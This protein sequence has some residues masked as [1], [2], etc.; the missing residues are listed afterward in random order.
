MVDV[1]ERSAQLQQQAKRD[2]DRGRFD[3]AER[4]L[5]TALD[6]LSEADADADRIDA[7]A[8][9]VRVLVTLSSVEV[10]L[11]GHEH[12]RNSLDEAH[13]I[14][15]E[16]ADSGLR[17]AVHNA[18]ALRSLRLGESDEALAEFSEAEEVS[19]SV[20]PPER[21]TLLLNRGNLY[22]HKLSLKAARR[23]LSRCI[24][25][26][27]EQVDTF[28]ELATHAFMARHNLGWLEF[29]AGNLP[30][31]LRLMDEAAARP[32]EVS[33]A[34]SALDK[35]R[36]LIEAGLS[37]A[38]DRTLAEAE[39][40]F[41]RGRLHQE[42]AETELARAD[43]AILSSNLRAA[44]RRA[45]SAR[46][47]F[48]RRG[49][50]R[51]SQMAELT[52]LATE[53]AD[54]ERPTQLV[55][56]AT[57]LADD[58]ATHHLDQH[59]RSATLI[60]ADALLRAGRTEEAG[61]TLAGL[62]PVSTTD[63]L[64]VA[65]HHRAVSAGLLAATGLRLAATREIR[66]GLAELARHQAQF[67]SIDLQTAAAI[68]GRD[69]VRLDLDLALADP[70]PARVFNTIER[71]R[72]VSRRLT[73]V[74]PRT[75]ESAELLAEL[76]QLNEVNKAMATDPSASGELAAV[77]QRIAELY[78]DLSAL[79]WRTVG[80]GE[81]LHPATMAR[82]ADAAERGGRT[83]VSYCQH[84]SRW[85]AVV[86]GDG[87]PHFVPL[88]GD[89]QILEL[90]R[91]SQADL[92]V[93]ALPLI[94]EP[95]R[96]S[97]QASLRRSLERIDRALVAPLRLPDRPLAI[98]PTGP[99]ATLAWNCLPSLRGRPVEVSPNATSWLWGTEAVDTH[100]DVDV[101]AFAGPGLTSAHSEASQVA[102]V[103]AGR[104][105]RQPHA[106]P[107]RGAGAQQDFA[108]TRDR[109]TRALASATV[110]HVAA[111]GSHMPQN[112]LF[113]SLELADGPLF[114][115]ELADREVAPHV[116][117]SACELGQATLRSGD[118]TLGLTRVL[119]QLGAQCVV[120]GVS[121]VEDECAATVM[122]D[123][124]R[125]LSAGADSATA[126]AAA[127]EHAGD[128]PFVCFGSSWRAVA[129]AG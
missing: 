86:L 7:S 88:P 40:E 15:D 42:R 29:L 97:A 11:Y 89:D 80:G 53:L 101:Q 108:A 14:A 45:R 20:P 107:G 31:A 41:R 100:G 72:A 102:Q 124:H 23:D 87:R 60:A 75:D 13:R 85:S 118:E 55:E 9:R 84:R 114:A 39:A 16:M 68:H 56:P 96:R 76:R 21:C 90:V 25:L 78:R 18:L 34:I 98:V 35:A 52:L 58:F 26:A 46:D 70:T 95:M 119:L 94:P 91:R 1:L 3:L 62:G 37:D 71:G 103:W 28:P 36:V 129:P 77:R 123:Y 105:L 8:T 24:A 19:G 69:L 112:P 128:V 126:L 122:V 125:R 50:D 93:L 30:A 59:A 81:V 79:S 44:R 66:R 63:P 117:L 6:K 73:A 120:A 99:I 82:V 116:V 67:G 12:G 48:R 109:L 121:Q 127:T 111:H 32:A 51:W 17:F 115:Y 4:R 49:S 57:R 65:L 33:L 113:S 27:D 5:R 74:T 110:V 83:L 47:R 22:L 92:N 61:S 38:A 104:P 43:C 64:H 10:E 2:C 106:E 54:G